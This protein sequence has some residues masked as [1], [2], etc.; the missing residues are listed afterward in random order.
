[1]Q[2]LQ[3]GG[4]NMGGALLARWAK[5]LDWAF[6]LVDPGS[7]EVPTGVHRVAE[8]ASLGE[9]TFDLMVVAVKPQL[10]GDVVPAFKDRLSPAGIV[11]SIAAG[12]PAE[13]FSQLLGDRPVVR[14]MPNLPVRIGE[15]MTG[16][17]GNDQV[18]EHER[19]AI[20]AL[21]APTGEAVWLDDEDGIDRFTAI[22]GSGPGY[23]FEMLRSYA[24]AA[25][26]LGF[27]TQEAAT[28]AMQTVKGTV[29][30][31]RDT[32]APFGTLRDSVTSKNGTTAA[33]LDV[34]RAEG[35]LEDLFREGTQA[36]YRRARALRA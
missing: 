32:G 18:G 12:T 5:A 14:A 25:E 33:G 9:A 27:D 19:G 21:F 36:A 10:V 28:M 6:T 17:F 30:L 13:R 4:G 23:I 8:P 22:A 29:E 34:F 7:P 35:G 24:A 26:T 15:G 1:M 20:D 2:V 16:L 11:V 31:A 3:I